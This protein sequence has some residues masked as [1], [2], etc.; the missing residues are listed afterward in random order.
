M[1]RGV[2]GRV[3][4]DSLRERRDARDERRKHPFGKGER[5]GR[6]GERIPSGKTIDEGGEAKDDR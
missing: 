4:G 1:S 6:G 5:R 3:R 2:G